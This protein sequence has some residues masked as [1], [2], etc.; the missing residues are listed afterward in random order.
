MESCLYRVIDIIGWRWGLVVLSYTWLAILT[1]FQGTLIRLCCG[2][3]RPV[4]RGLATNAVMGQCWRSMVILNVML[5]PKVRMK[6]GI[7]IDQIACIWPGAV[8]GK[9]CVYVSPPGT[10]FFD[11]LDVDHRHVVE[12]NML[13]KWHHKQTSRQA[14]R[15]RGEISFTRQQCILCT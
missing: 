11:S 4:E 9:V 14:D 13:I 8:K 12:P 3:L 10:A 5:A 6:A 15:I 2:R 1:V 7:Q